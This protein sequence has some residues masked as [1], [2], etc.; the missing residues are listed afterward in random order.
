M[1]NFIL[2]KYMMCVFNYLAIGIP[3]VLRG[4]EHT[5]MSQYQSS[6]FT[7]LAQNS[8]EYTCI[9]PVQKVIM[10]SYLSVSQICSML[11]RKQIINKHISHTYIH[12]CKYFHISQSIFYD[13]ND[14]KLAI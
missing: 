14:Y 5:A 4:D 3:K 6:A 11:I 1:F 9:L 2:Q 10:Y 12:I 8:N 13:R 7:L